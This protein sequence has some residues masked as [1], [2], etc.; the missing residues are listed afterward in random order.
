MFFLTNH[1]QAV[2][3][4]FMFHGHVV[5]VN[6]PESSYMRG[7]HSQPQ[8][9][10]CSIHCFCIVATWKD[11]LPDY[12]WFNCPLSLLFCSPGKAL[13]WIGHQLVLVDERL[14]VVE[15]NLVLKTVPCSEVSSWHDTIRIWC[16]QNW[17]TMMITWLFVC[18]LM[19][20]FSCRPLR[21]SAR[22]AER[23]A[24]CWWICWWWWRRWRWWRW[25]WQREQWWGWGWR[26][27]WSKR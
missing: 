17:L 20:T 6:K 4:L 16:D 10:N 14:G 18:L 22:P 3:D 19:N 5:E 15:E 24:H 23:P 21:C 12:I 27:W 9:F 25:W 11:W 1:L 7:I 13:L 8:I 26:W 2:V